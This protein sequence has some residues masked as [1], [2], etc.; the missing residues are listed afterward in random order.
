LE[1]YD[2]ANDTWMMMA[3][4]PA[5]RSFFS[6]CVESTGPT[7]EQDIFDTLIDKSLLSV[8]L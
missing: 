6:V 8:S 2:V 4:M 5:G 7:E 1:R 3:R